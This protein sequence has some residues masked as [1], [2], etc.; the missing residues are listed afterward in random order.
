MMWS[1]EQ[2]PCAC[3][4]CSS[5][6][7]NQRLVSSACAVQRLLCKVFFYLTG[8]CDLASSVQKADYGPNNELAIRVG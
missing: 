6:T 7:K 3:S 4:A 8:S 2:K 1:V 5:R